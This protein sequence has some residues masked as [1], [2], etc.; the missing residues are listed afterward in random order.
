MSETTLF[1]TGIFTFGALTQDS[2]GRPIPADQRLRDLL[3]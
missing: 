2:D 1:E 3:E